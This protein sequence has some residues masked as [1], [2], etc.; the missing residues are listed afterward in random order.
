MEKYYIYKLVSPNGKIYIGQTNDFDLRM[1]GHKRASERIDNKL[2]K[3][4]RKYGWDTFTKEILAEVYGK[5]N[6]D[7][8]EISLISHYKSA[9]RS[10]LNT[11]LTP[12]GGDV[13]QGRYDT[14]E[15]MEFVQRM[16]E[17]VSGSKNPMYGKNH[18]DETK[19]KQK[20]KA[21]GRYSL[22][23]FKERNG[24]IE[25]ERLYEERRKWLK[26]RNLPKGEKGRFIISQ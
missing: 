6:A 9:S 16:K 7:A 10:G 20:A 25:G 14:D 4:V 19:A 1:Y 5:Q 26:S 12:Q 17:T 22:D 2:Y 21:K 23:W 24:D 11:L 8:M 15:Y 18:S 3:C 13:W